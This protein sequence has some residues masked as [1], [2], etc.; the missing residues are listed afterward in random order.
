MYENDPLHIHGEISMFLTLS[1]KTVLVRDMYIRN[2][3]N[4]TGIFQKRKLF[5]IFQNK[6]SFMKTQLN[7]V[8]VC[9]YGILEQSTNYSI[10]YILSK[11]K[12][13]TKTN[14][15]TSLLL[16]ASLEVFFSFLTWSKLDPTS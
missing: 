6:N 16:R 5:C 9:V 13:L 10:L 1:S 4:Q 7:Q 3:K 8:C 11:N 2:S 14:L 15:D 12:I